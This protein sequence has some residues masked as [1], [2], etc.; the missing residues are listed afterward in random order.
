[1]EVAF[2]SRFVAIAHDTAIRKRH[3]ILIWL[4]ARLLS[5]SGWRGEN[6]GWG[7]GRIVGALANRVTRFPIK[8]LAMFCAD[9]ALPLARFGTR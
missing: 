5:S 6:S 9:T 4:F 1:M 2:R 7:Y 3:G 8:P